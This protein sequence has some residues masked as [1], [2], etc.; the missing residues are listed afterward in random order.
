MW[1]FW[2]AH[3]IEWITKCYPGDTNP[4]QEAQRPLLSLLLDFKANLI[5]QTPQIPATFKRLICISCSLWSKWNPSLVGFYPLVSHSPPTPPLI[6]YACLF[7]PL[8]KCLAQIIKMNKLVGPRWPVLKSAHW[9]RACGGGKWLR[10]PA[11]YVC[12]C[13]YIFTH[14]FLQVLHV[15]QHG[16]LKKSIWLH[17]PVLIIFV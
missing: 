3:F 14:T 5:P 4:H 13:V 2:G 7:Y 6:T 9:T 16:T 17:S 8:P 1:L 11:V 12:G 10:K 15:H